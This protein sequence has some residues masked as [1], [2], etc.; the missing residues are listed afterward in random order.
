MLAEQST[1]VAVAFVDEEATVGAILFPDFDLDQEDLGG[2][3][4]WQPPLVTTLV[5]QYNVYFARLLN[6]SDDVCL[7]TSSNST[8]ASGDLSVATAN[9]TNDTVAA[10]ATTT[11][12]STTMK[13][14]GDN[15]TLYLWCRRYFGTSLVGTNNIVVPID[16]ARQDSTHILV[17]TES[18][19][20][21]QTTPRSHLIFDAFAS[22]SN[23][24]F[25]DKDLDPIEL[26]GSIVWSAPDY[27]Q[28]LAAYT[29]YFASDE[30][31]SGRSQIDSDR[32]LGAENTFLPPELP[33]GSFTH[34]VVYTK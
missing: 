22:V 19:L 25:T 10:V 26:G 12:T 6:G 2:T 32:T 30:S 16:F 29:I 13:S 21:E 3:V 1:P 14:I 4:E 17:Y 5:K 18:T 15:Q 33:M 34:T 11:Q 31:G 24:S 27:T 28:R 8:N 23:V 7:V 9:L 20:V